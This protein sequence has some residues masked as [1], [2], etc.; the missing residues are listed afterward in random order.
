MEKSQVPGSNNVAN[1]RSTA[2]RCPVKQFEFE[3]TRE[4]SRKSSAPRF[5]T[6]VLRELPNKWSQ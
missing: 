4:W 5:S 6:A 1:R 2:T 3:L